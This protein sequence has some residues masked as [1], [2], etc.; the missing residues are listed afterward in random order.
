MNAAILALDLNATN[1]GSAV[2]SLA[3]RWELVVGAVILVI[4]AFVIL[5]F[6]KNIIANAIVGFIALLAAKFIFG[7]AIPLNGVTILVTLLGG[8]GG[9]AA[10][11]LAYFFGWL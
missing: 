2:G 1:V 7:I 8:L 6:L 9:V 5:Y 10:L 3:G 11:F 4:G